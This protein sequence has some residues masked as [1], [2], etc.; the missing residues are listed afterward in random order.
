MKNVVLL[1]YSF[2]PDK[3]VAALRPSYWSTQLIHSGFKV[4]VVTSSKLVEPQ[5][6]DNH[7][8]YKRIE[9][10]SKKSS[11]NYLIS[12]QGLQWGNAIKKEFLPLCKTVDLL[13]IT[14]G[15]FLQMSLA[16]IF[17]KQFNSKVILDFRDPFS[18][19]PRFND[20]VI[21][22]TTKRFLEWRFCLRADH[23]ITVNQITAKL[24]ACTPSKISIIDNGFDETIVNEI[25]SYPKTKSDQTKIIHTGK[26]YENASPKNLI[27]AIESIDNVLFENYGNMFEEH[28]SSLKHCK[29]NDFVDYRSALR[30]VHDSD[31]GIVFTTGEAFL[32]TTK[33][34]DYI[35][36]KK[37]ILIITNGFIR[38]GNIH[39][40]TKGNPNV[41]WCTNNQKEIKLAIKN[42]IAREYIDTKTQHLSRGYGFIKLLNIIQAL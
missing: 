15:P 33:I 17:K 7:P 11:R 4:T 6:I 32:S 14:G 20:S 39:E 23:V 16:K 40:I 27:D 26:F 21:K 38:T 19:N 42:L 28:N 10:T 30:A 41:E 3:S 25:L 22:L 2:F 13:I 8:N 5:K 31:I 37:K 24:L 35:G 9:I 34:F 1:A 18:N 36:M 29:F 12:D